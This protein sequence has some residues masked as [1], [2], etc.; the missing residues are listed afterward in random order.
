MNKIDYEI[1][2]LGDVPLLSGKTLIKAKL[3][4]K[5]YGS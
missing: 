3:A 2:D 5:T 1:F 4:Y